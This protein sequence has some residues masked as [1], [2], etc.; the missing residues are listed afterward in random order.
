MLLMNFF[1]NIGGLFNACLERSEEYALPSPSDAS[2]LGRRIGE[3]SLE[4]NERQNSP[5]NKGGAWSDYHLVLVE[6]P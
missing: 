6:Y 5:W 1:S 4:F 3:I 2:N